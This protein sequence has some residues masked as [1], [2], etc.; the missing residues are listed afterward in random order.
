MVCNII[1]YINK[2]EIERKI[3]NKNNNKII[4]RNT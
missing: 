2:R 4:T 3:L 1:I